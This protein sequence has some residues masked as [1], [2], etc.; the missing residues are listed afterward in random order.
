MTLNIE[1][2]TNADLSQGWRPGNNAGG[3]SLFKALGH[4]LAAPKGHAIIERLKDLGP[5]A[6]YD[7]TGAIG[8]FH[9]YYDLSKVEI[10]GYYVQRV[11]DLDQPFLGHDAK[12]VSSCAKSDAAVVLVL[13]FDAQKVLGPIS[14]CFP[15]DATIVTLDDMRIPDE[16][17]TNQRNYLD[18]M[19]FAKIGRAHV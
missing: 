2:F 8:N 16:M 18:P 6:I 9:S 5:V 15:K 1:T 17:L 19:N 11:E 4:P 14:H 10:E 7:P 13:L 12:P 3:A